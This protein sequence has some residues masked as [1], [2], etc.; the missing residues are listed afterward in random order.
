[1]LTGGFLRAPSRETAFS[2]GGICEHR[3]HALDS[4]I[5]YFR[6][7]VYGNRLEGGY[8]SM[9]TRFP[10]DPIQRIRELS[11]EREYHLL[12]LEHIETRIQEMWWNVEAGE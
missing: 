6:A 12:A 1:M 2:R 9:I 4:H 5:V 10:V 3:R 8:L 7:G 11:E